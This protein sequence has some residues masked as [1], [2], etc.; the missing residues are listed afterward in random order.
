[1]SFDNAEYLRVIRKNQ[2]MEAQYPIPPGWSATTRPTA[3]ACPTTSGSPTSCST[4]SAISAAA[5]ATAPGPTGGRWSGTTLPRRPRATAS[6][7]SCG[8]NPSQ[9]IG[10][11]IEVDKNKFPEELKR[12]RACQLQARTAAWIADYPDGDDFMQLLYGP[13]S[14]QNNSACFQLPEWDRIYETTKAMPASP[15]RDQLYRK[16]WRMAELYGVWKLHDTRYR[17]MLV[18]PQVVGYKK[19][20]ILVADFM[21][22]DLDNSRRRR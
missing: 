1:M 16:L 19:H 22:Y 3:P 11:R 14:H 17:N 20:P 13:N 6:S 4:T 10:I 21:Y 18:Q 2:A 15:E 12:E 9:R 5:T 7:T 8:R